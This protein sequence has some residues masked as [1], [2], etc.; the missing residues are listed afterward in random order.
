MGRKLIHNCT[1]TLIFLMLCYAIQAQKKLTQQVVHLNN[2]GT[3]RGV[4]V[5]QGNQKIYI[6]TTDGSV[7]VFYKNEID[8]VTLQKNFNNYQYNK[9]GF[10]HFT[11]L[12][13]LVA[14]KTTIDGVTTAAFSF[15]TVNGYKF[16]QYAF[17]G[18][19]AGAD[20]YATQTIIPLFISFRGD[21]KNE[22]SVLPFY[23]AEAGYGVNITQN[24]AGGENFKGGLSYAA[25][26]G[27][28]IPFNKKAGFLLGL[29]YRY[30]KTAYTITLQQKEVLYRRLTVRAG[31]FL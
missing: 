31:F 8:S 9:K 20:L 16:S 17:A 11:E 6:Q 26:A 3:I 28:K 30:Q 25:G 21:V 23:F 18:I 5:K 15:Q 27:I 4:I 22:G 2:G 24:S 19:G 12:G 13:P 7:W 10:A 1:G 29:G 14:G